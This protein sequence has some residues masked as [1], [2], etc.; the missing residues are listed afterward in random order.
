M[1][2]KLH[3]HSLQTLRLSRLGVHL[4][5]GLGM[6]LIAFPW[7]AP[8][9]QRAIKQRWSRHLLHCLGIRLTIHGSNPRPAQGMLVANHISWLDVFVINA[10]AETTFVCKNEVRGWPVLGMLCARS[11]TV[12]I[13]RGSRSATRRVN[14]TLTTRLG[15]GECIAVFPEGTTG[16]GSHLMPFRPG[17]LQAAIDADRPLQPLALRYLDHRGEITAEV[18]Y[19]GD[20]SFWQSLCA[21]AGARGITANLALLNAIPAATLTRRELAEHTQHA[22]H[23][24]LSPPAVAWAEAKLNPCISETR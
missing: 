11:G 22:I 7:L 8:A 21:I 24:A 19:V 14:E 12:F 23:A 5:Y 20:T 18:A 2:R 17:L 9:R 16:N 4:T 6:V 10:I 13:D 15:E 3:R 1:L